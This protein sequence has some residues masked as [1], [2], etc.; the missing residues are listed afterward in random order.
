MRRG[1]T[2][3]W[4]EEEEEEEKEEE[5]EESVRRE[6]RVPSELVAAELVEWRNFSKLFFKFSLMNRSSF[7]TA[8]CGRK[9]GVDGRS[10]GRQIIN[11]KSSRTS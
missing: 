1:E 8:S 3:V 10:K 7:F 2:R 6:A 4:N 9:G 11:H 5:E